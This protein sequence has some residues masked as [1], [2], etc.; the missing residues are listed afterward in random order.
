[1]EQTWLKRLREGSITI[2][3]QQFLVQQ[4]DPS[5]AKLF[6]SKANAFK[7]KY[8]ENDKNSIFRSD[9][10]LEASLKAALA[11]T[12]KNDVGMG[13]IIENL[14]QTR[15]LRET[16]VFHQYMPLVY[17]ANALLVLY[18][19]GAKMLQK[20]REYQRK[21]QLERAVMIRQEREMLLQQ[22]RN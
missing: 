16:L 20:F 1:M 15:Y 11:Q 9:E 21:R 18:C 3:G 19:I 14:K 6:R 2:K 12:T 22:L 10:T 5:M 4:L 17:L 7:A 13:I 8:F